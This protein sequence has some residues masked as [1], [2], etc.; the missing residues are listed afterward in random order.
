M[1]GKA[2]LKRAE[3]FVEFLNASPTPFHAVRSAKQRLEKAG[4][5]QIKERDSWTS[6]L[7]PGGK[8]YLTRNASTVVAF[9]IGSQWKPGNPVA[10]VG[11]HTDSPCLRIKPVSKRTA[12]G[13]MQVGVETYGGGMWH[14]WFDRDLGVAGRVMVKTSNGDMEQRL[15]R[16]SRPVCRIPNLAVHFGGSVPFEFNK[17]AQ[18]FP[19]T[20]LVSAEL[21]RTGKTAEETKKAEVEAEKAASFEPLKTPKQ[22]HHPYLITLI[23]EEAGCKEDEILDFELVLYDTQPA[24]IG[25]LNNEFVFSARL[26][27]LGMTYCAVEGIIQSL[28][29]GPSALKNDSTIRL[30]ACFDHEEIGSTSAQGADSNMLPAVLRRLSCLPSTP[31]SSDSDKSYDKMSTGDENSTAF[32]QTLAT[33]LLVSAD[34]AHSVNPNYGGKYESE[35]RPEM[36]AGTVIKINANVRY[37]TNAPGVVL[38]AEC[39]KRAKAATYQPPG[40][41]SASGGVP[42]QMFVVRN[43]S[44]CGSTIGPMLSAKLG[45]RTIDVGN[46][47]LAMHSIRETGGCYDV[48][49]GVNLFDAFF[50]HYGELESKVMVD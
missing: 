46:P 29:S 37:A 49:H 12:D 38:L 41:K 45:A 36:N 25:G 8:Y 15:V 13:F 5:K 27:N 23:A 32:E 50:E 40:S 19:I 24:C 1:A 7:Q 34:M 28:S 11:A 47:Q 39:A 48:E 10:M 44:A 18:L 42:L 6:T 20:G 4:F 16:I 33:S 3:D 9:A 17:E 43:D 30:I 2:S 22:R 31:S 21:N 14:T 35:H 26:D